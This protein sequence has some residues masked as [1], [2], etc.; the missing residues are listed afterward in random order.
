MSA[1]SIGAA[2]VTTRSAGKPAAT[3]STSSTSV[4]MI[5]SYWD[6]WAIA[7]M[8]ISFGF[9][10]GQHVAFSVEVRRRKNA[11]YSEIG[12]FFKR[13]GLSIIAADERDVIRVRTNI[14]GEDDYLYRIR[15]PLPA[16]RSLFLRLRRAGGPACRHAA[17]L[18]HPHR[19]LHHAG[20][21]HD[22]ANRG[23]SAMELSLAVHGLSARVCVPRRGPGST[24]SRSR[25]CARWAASPI[26][27]DSRTAATP[28][29]RTFAKAFPPWI[30]RIC[31][32]PTLVPLH[33]EF[34]RL[35]WPG[36]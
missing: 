33:C 26:A 9:D 36:G 7:H 27:P 19:Q 25:S 22:E 12:G 28:S 31:R 29:L 24:L 10:D 18:Q 13:D 2:T 15:M 23:L 1:T 6:G 21:S 30:L 20:L 34:E 3:I 14:R 4:D 17:F 35:G 8:L 5:M 32:R 11:T 16:M